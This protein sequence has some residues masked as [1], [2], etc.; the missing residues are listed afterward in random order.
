MVT[1]STGEGNPVIG[2]SS[3]QKSEVL[4]HLPRPSVVV[5]TPPSLDSQTKIRQSHCLL[6]AAST[7]LH[8]PVKSWGSCTTSG[9]ASESLLIGP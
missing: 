5:R 9:K 1:T 2:I 6:M 3:L 8:A 4:S 7:P